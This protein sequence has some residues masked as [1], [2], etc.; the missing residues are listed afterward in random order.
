SSPTFVIS[1]DS[2]LSA[3]LGACVCAKARVRFP[4]SGIVP[5]GSIDAIYGYSPEPTYWLPSRPHEARSFRSAK[6]G[7]RK[8]M[9]GS[10]INR[11]PAETE[12]KRPQRFPGA[13]RDEPS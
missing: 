7:A 8:S 5:T 10:S 3:G 11:H 2:Q 12:G 6:V 4:P 9:N 13:K 1:I